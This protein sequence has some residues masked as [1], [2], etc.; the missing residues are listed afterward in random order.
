ME[1]PARPRGF[2]EGAGACPR[3]GARR[4]SPEDENDRF[5]TIVSFSMSDGQ[6]VVSRRTGGSLTVTL[7]EDTE[8]EFDGS[9]SGSPEDATLADVQP[10][11]VV[12][13]LEIDDDSGEV[14]ELE[15]LPLTTS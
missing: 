14:E 6:L 11:M 15:L 4:G 3:A 5:G 7:T 12:A 2:L 9:G 1:A 8:I 13:E 10:G